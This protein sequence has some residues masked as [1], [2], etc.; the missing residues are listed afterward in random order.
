M[1]TIRSTQMTALQ[2]VLLEDSIEALVVEI[3]GDFP[4]AAVDAGDEEIRASITQSLEAAPGFGFESWAAVSLL[5]K[6][7]FLLGE[8]PWESP[9]LKVLSNVLR[10]TSYG[11]EAEKMEAFAN[12][13]AAH[14][15]G[16]AADPAGD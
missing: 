2:G 11:T 15:D 12:A 1:L 9:E 14:V 13:V 10:D 3:H 8:A 5:A 6:L 16:V 4:E 7:T